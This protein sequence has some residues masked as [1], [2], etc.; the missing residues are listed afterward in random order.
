MTSQPEPSDNESESNRSNH[1]EDSA[2]ATL[3]RTQDA[4]QFYTQN[5]GNFRLDSIF[6]D[7]KDQQEPMEEASYDFYRPVVDEMVDSVESNYM[8]QRVSISEENG[9]YNC[10][11]CNDA[12]ERK[13]VLL[14]HLHQVHKIKPYSCDKCSKSFARVTTLRL[15]MA[16]SHHI[17]ILYSCDICD[18]SFS[19]N[20]ALRS[21]LPSHT[22]SDP[23]SLVCDVCNKTFTAR[24][25][26]Y[27]HIRNVHKG[28]SLKGHRYHCDECGNVFFSYAALGRHR[29]RVHRIK[30]DSRSAAMPGANTSE[31]NNV[32]N[33]PLALSSTSNTS[34][35]N[36]FGSNSIAI[37]P[38]VQ[39]QIEDNS[40][41]MASIKSHFERNSMAIDPVVQEQVEGNSLAMAAVNTALQYGINSHA[42]N[43]SDSDSDA[44]SVTSTS[45]QNHGE[46]D[47]DA[48]STSST[49]SRNH[50]ESDSDASSVAS[51]SAPKYYAESDSDVRSAASLTER[52]SRT[53]PFISTSIQNHVNSSSRSIPTVTGSNAI[54]N[55]GMGGLFPNPSFPNVAVATEFES[56]EAKDMRQIPYEEWLPSY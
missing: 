19:T 6:D 43:Y 16:R 56:R 40:V 49:S 37:D 23:D 22:M 35:E 36:P 10:D 47:S 46:S 52:D 39:E 53:I 44:S 26:L 27:R 5:F 12:F 7:S 20:K 17:N 4:F 21:H 48:S 41:A 8:V 42:Q 55:Q 51:N 29:S 38:I 50:E 13:D 54:Q 31:P 15:H 3:P 9:K 45:G 2:A 30:G 24:N 11:I 34:V 28:K 33:S 18:K 1:D 25:S 32:V 14:G